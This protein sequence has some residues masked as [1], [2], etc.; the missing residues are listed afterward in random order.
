[1]PR[2]RWRT[3]YALIDHLR[4][5]D[6]PTILARLADRSISRSEPYHRPAVGITRP[7]S[8][9]RSDEI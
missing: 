8:K 1:M 7:N 9:A 4:D 2:M 3:L 5:Y 6:L